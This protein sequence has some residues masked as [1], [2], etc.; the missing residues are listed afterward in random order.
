ML[1]RLVLRS[2]N[3]FFAQLLRPP[4]VL[5][6]LLE[7]GTLADDALLLFNRKWPEPVRLPRAS[8][9]K[10]R[11]R[12]RANKIQKGHAHKV[13]HGHA[14]AL[15]ERLAADLLPV[16]WLVVAVVVLFLFL[17]FVGPSARAVLRPCLA[18]ASAHE[19]DQLGHEIVDVERAGARFHRARFGC[20]HVGRRH[21][22]GRVE[23]R[24]LWRGH[25]EM[26]LSK[27]N[28]RDECWGR[29][30]SV[31]GKIYTP[32]SKSESASCTFS[33]N[34]CVVYSLALIWWP[35][36]RKKGGGKLA[37]SLVTAI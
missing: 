34:S 36:Q 17:V 8:G 33:S 6:V 12:A 13:H 10:P 23:R 19:G 21:E 7:F 20:V 4:L 5:L 32:W 27:K 25:L 28:R 2:R 24:F 30:G 35:R 29:R 31:C 22:E 1:R 3:V 26:D 37:S 16:E 15:C 14:P 18:A 11:A 9:Q